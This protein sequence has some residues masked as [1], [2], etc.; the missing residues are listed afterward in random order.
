MIRIQ[1]KNSEATRG[2]KPLYRRLGTAAMETAIA[3]PL[4]VMVVFG[5]IEI[6]NAVFL[7]QSVNM[8]AYEAAKVI[9]RPGD[10]EA[11]ARTRCQEILSVRK[12]ST[13]TL[14][15]S[16]TVTTATARGTQVTVTLVAPASNLS[17]GPVQFMSG[18]TISCTVVMVRL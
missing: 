9:T 16:P 5:S 13:F 8:A 4:L 2:K 10:N 11:L 18:R 1:T 15:F 14:T 3:L 17:Y 12:V 7:R 6:A